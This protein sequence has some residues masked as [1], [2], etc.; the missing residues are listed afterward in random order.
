MN[1]QNIKQSG[2]LHSRK[3]SPKSSLDRRVRRARPAAADPRMPHLRLPTAVPLPRNAS[4]MSRRDWI[5]FVERH[6]SRLDRVEGIDRIK[7]ER[8]RADLMRARR[9][10]YHSLGVPCPP[11]GSDG[12]RPGRSHY[13]GGR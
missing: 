1:N 12:R 3:P 9:K 10:L 13:G 11:W 6:L 7:L 4:S 5:R 2:S 8:A